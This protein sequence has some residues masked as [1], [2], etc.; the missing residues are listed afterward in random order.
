MKFSQRLR[1]SFV[2]R[3]SCHF[4]RSFAETGVSEVPAPPGPR[5]RSGFDGLSRKSPRQ[6][7]GRSVITRANIHSLDPVRS[8][9]DDAVVP[10]IMLQ[11]CRFV[12]KVILI[13]QIRL[14]G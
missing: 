6:S 12:D 11:R 2:D 1:P 8:F 4:H 3:G 7:T 9:H 10:A 14:Y 5:T 13:A